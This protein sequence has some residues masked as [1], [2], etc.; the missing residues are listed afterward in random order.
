MKFNF[1]E[2]ILNFFEKIFG[3]NKKQTQMLEAPNVQIIKSKK[4]EFVKSLQV[5][6]NSLIKKKNRMKTHI[7][8]GDGLG[9]NNKISRL[10]FIIIK[11]VL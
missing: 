3:K 6:I 7:S 8:V 2:K 4:E 10:I 1:L 5:N 11:V 9:F